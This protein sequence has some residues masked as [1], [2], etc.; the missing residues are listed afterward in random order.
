M[1]KYLMALLILASLV[2]VG[3]WFIEPAEPPLTSYGP[4]LTGRLEQTWLMGEGPGRQASFSRDGTLLA[5]ADATGEVV[6]RRVSDW[7]VAAR[8][9]H[10]RGATAVAF[11]PGN[12]LL[13]AGYDGLVRRWDLGSSRE[14]QRYVGA[15]GTLWTLDVSPDGTRV[16]AASEDA[17]IRIWPLTGDAPPMTLKGHQRNVWNIRFSPDGK[18][19]ASGSFDHSARIWNV[20]TGKSLRTLRGHD[21][22]VVGLG[23]S[24]DGKTLVTGGD[25]STIRIWRTAD[26]E[27]INRIDAGNHIYSVDLSADG[28]WLATGGRARGAFRTFWH[29]LAGGGSDAKPAKIW[30]THDMALVA[31]LPHPEDVMSVAF[32]ADGRWLV[33]SSEDG[34]ARLWRLVAQPR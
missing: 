3:L 22:A 13:T 11:G 5:T 31:A 29:Q 25:D 16:A 14:L 34:K 30:R 26:G 33:T 8:L 6:V 27:P 32:S 18:Q 19:L 24:K 28:R 4:R 2:A 17:I 12:Q 7:K 10:H 9:S 23:Y 21:Q 1:R 20:G 15:E